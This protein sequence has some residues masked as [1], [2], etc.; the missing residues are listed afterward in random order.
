[1]NYDERNWQMIVRHLQD[2]NKYK[3]IVASNRAQLIDD[4]LNLARAGYLDYGVALNVTRYLVH[5]T[6]YVPWKAAI[7]ALNYIDSMFIRTRN[8]GL[9]KVRFA[10]H[11]SD[12]CLLSLINLILSYQFLL[13][14]ILWI[15]W[16]TSTTRLVLKIIA[17]ARC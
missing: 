12:C 10:R 6:D 13:R 17:I 3:T 1:M 11:A 2:R 9:F 5:E 7:A 15:C 4:A 16:K 14:N 8:Y